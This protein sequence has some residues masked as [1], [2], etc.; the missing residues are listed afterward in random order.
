[1]RGVFLFFLESRG[2]SEAFIEADRYWLFPCYPLAETESWRSKNKSM[3]QVQI[4]QTVDGGITNVKV[5]F[6]DGRSSFVLRERNHG[7]IPWKIA[8]K[9]G[10]ERNN[11]EV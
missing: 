11:P 6:C 9:Q 2:V 10:F 4:A 8:E 3:K 5:Y 1:M 7:S